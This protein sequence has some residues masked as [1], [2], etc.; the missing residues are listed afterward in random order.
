MRMWARNTSRAALLAAGA[1][2]VGAAF[3]SGAAIADT[4]TSG[5]FSVL[6]GNQVV[7]PISVPL[8]VSGNSVAALGASQ[9]QSEGGAH[10]SGARHG[11][12][13]TCRR[14]ATSRSA[15]ATR[16]W[17]RSACRSTSAATPSR[18]SG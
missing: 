2:A 4:T 1:V 13:A 3:G 10:V 16:S 9:A 6:G 18:S 17:R 11:G 15:A 8:E 14:P 7:A 12:A 5:N